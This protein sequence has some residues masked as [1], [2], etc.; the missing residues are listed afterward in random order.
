M[1]AAPKSLSEA[2]VCRTKSGQ[3]NTGADVR[4]SFSSWNAVLCSSADLQEDFFFSN[5]FRGMAVFANSGTKRRYHYATPKNLR[6]LRM[7]VSAGIVW[8]Q[9]TLS[10]SVRM[11]SAVTKC[12]KYFRFFLPNLHLSGLSF[13]LAA[14]SLLT[15]AEICQVLFECLYQE[16]Y[17]VEVCKAV[18]IHVGDNDSVH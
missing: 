5:R 18:R 14:R 4:Q 13:K 8:I 17:I 1:T 12:P 15:T 11:P 9:S 16:D 10:G 3:T 7:L 6:T 2:S